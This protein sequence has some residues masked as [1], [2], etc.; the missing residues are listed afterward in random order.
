MDDLKVYA[1]SREKLQK[2]IDISLQFSNDNP[3][4]IRAGPELLIDIISND[5][6]YKYLQILQLMGPYHTAV[7]ES[8]AN[9]F[10][11]HLKAILETSLDSGN[12]I[13]IINT[14]VIPL[15]TSSFKLIK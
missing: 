4:A 6:L 13:K 3:Y 7:K 2:L 12:N 9:A 11:K 5:D 1:S 8:L 10:V 14:Y 15:F